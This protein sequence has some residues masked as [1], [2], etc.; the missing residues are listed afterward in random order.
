MNTNN[1]ISSSSGAECL[2]TGATTHKT[3]NDKAQADL[4]FKL[5]SQKKITLGSVLENLGNLDQKLHTMLTKGLVMELGAPR[6]PHIYKRIENWA[7]PIKVNYGSGEHVDRIATLNKMV[8]EEGLS[9]LFPFQDTE[10]CAVNLVCSIETVAFLSTNCGRDT[11]RAQLQGIALGGN[12]Q[13]S[14]EHFLLDLP[15]APSTANTGNQEAV[16]KGTIGKAIAQP[17]ENK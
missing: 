7:N 15:D 11:S 8:E 5:L 6:Y 3:A 17:T 2:D 1:T 12:W 10:I 13:D 16:R 4:M 9:V 14:I